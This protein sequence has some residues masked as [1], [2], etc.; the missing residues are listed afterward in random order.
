M[1]TVESKIVGPVGGTLT[2]AKA[3]Y[4]PTPITN[5][6]LTAIFQLAPTIHIDPCLVVA[7]WDMET[8][9]GTSARW[10]TNGNPAGLAIEKPT[11]PDPATFTG[12]Q[13]AVVHLW[14]LSVAMAHREGISAT[15]G[16]LPS[17]AV[18]FCQRWIA[19]YKD[20]NCPIVVSIADLQ[21][22]YKDSTGESQSTWAWDQSY[23]AQVTSRANI[24]F[25]NGGGKTNWPRVILNP[26]HRN[27]TGGD[28]EE[29][30]FTPK[31]ATAYLNTFLGAGVDT[32][33]LGDTDGSLDAVCR[34]I[35]QIIETTKGPCL[36][37]DLHLEGSPVPG[38]FAI[39]PDISG[40]ITNAP[41][42]QNSADTWSNN[43]RDRQL[44]RAI[45]QNIARAT[46]LTLR[47]GVRE[48]GLMDEHETGVGGDGYRL[49]VFAYTSPYAARVVRLVIEHGNHTVEPDRSIIFA[50]GFAQKCAD[51]AVVAFKSIYG[52]PPPKPAQWAKPEVPDWWQ[53][54]L[55]FKS[56]GDRRVGD[57]WWYVARRTNLAIK[58]VNRYSR[59]D[60]SS[61]KSGPVIAVG[62]KVKIERVFFGGTPNKRWWGVEPDGHFIIVDWTRPK[63]RVLP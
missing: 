6:Y 20:R 40:L 19:K 21:R 3:K 50:D 22:R 7:Q 1:Y 47:E 23:A 15:E 46:G 41:I 5:A 36:F 39:V 32:V 61:P 48:L 43:T 57:V 16:R 56:P 35:N 17:S 31:L 44:G 53:E 24:T 4:A 26:G 62:E 13:A 28:P 25:P 27:T 52:T 42:Q 29:A 38:V 58:V 2:E 60:S 51:A 10:L 45:A 14:A 33:N 63:I 34:R 8:G 11:D 54:A 49:A 55:S 30:A 37:L 9:G 12:D 59:P 18:P